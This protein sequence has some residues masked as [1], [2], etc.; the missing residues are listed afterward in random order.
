MPKLSVP[1][2]SR[3]PPSNST[4]NGSAPYISLSLSLLMAAACGVSVANIY[5]NQ[6]MLGVIGATFPED[7]A[8]AGMVPTAT[9]IGYALGLLLL[10]PLGDRIERRLLI[11][12]QFGGLAL[13]LAAVALAPNA[14]A[15]LSASVFVGVASSVAQQILPFAAELSAPSR[16]GA[17]IGL[18]MSG[19]LCGILFGRA[20]AGTVAVHFGWRTMFWLGLALAVLVGMVLAFALPKSEPKTN[21]SYGELVRS[22]ATLWREEPRLRQATLIQAFVFGS[23]SVLWTTLA[24]YLDAQY[25]LGADVAGMFGLIG[26]VGVL[27]APVAGRLADQRGPHFVIGLSIGTMIVSWFVFGA[28]GM[29]AGLVVG[30]LLLDFGAQGSQVSNQ[31]VIQGL[32]PA[33]RNRLNATLMTGMFLGGALGSAAATLA[34]EY[35]GWIAVCTVGAAWSAAAFAVHARSHKHWHSGPE[36]SA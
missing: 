27:F 33:A 23:F 35:F 22:L 15:L 30:V 18:V 29:V 5:Y 34:W 8:V 25:H 12:L 9:Q 14:W 6:P 32:R 20:L 26:A 16:R 1:Q 2:A 21:S 28:W 36:R 7:R 10:V 31:H 13:S 3:Q 11:V 19:L 17:T 4:K 24:L